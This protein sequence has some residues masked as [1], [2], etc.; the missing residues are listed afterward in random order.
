METKKCQL[1]TTKLKQDISQ[2]SIKEARESVAYYGQQKN[3][4]FEARR[5]HFD[6]LKVRYGNE[7]IA[8]AKINEVKEKRKAEGKD[9]YTLS[10]DSI[11]G[12]YI[13]SEK[14]ILKASKDE[15]YTEEELEKLRREKDKEMD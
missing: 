7:V 4:A 5:T 9:H 2:Q 11:V 15:L 12:Q 1:E 13:D 14:T 10:Q 8:K 6:R 3:E